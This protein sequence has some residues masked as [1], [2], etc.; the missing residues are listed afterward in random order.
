MISSELHQIQIP[1]ILQLNKKCYSSLRALDR[2]RNRMLENLGCPLSGH[3]G[4]LWSFF[5]SLS[6]LFFSLLIRR[7]WSS[8]VFN[9]SF[10]NRSVASKT[11]SKQPNSR[12][13]NNVTSNN[14]KEHIC[15]LEQDT[16]ALLSI[17]KILNC[18]PIEDV[19]G[20]L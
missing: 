3:Q 8:R 7:K 15:M 2:M 4:T 12:W 10:T 14:S 19:A 20:V 17:D 5:E 13:I 16:S 1:E 6:R 11:S 9:K 18:T